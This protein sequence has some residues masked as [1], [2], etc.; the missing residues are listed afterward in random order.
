MFLS[1]GGRGCFGF[2]LFVL[3]LW[4][5]KNWQVSST[6]SPFL[7]RNSTCLK[8]PR[9][10]TLLLPNWI[11]AFFFWCHLDQNQPDLTYTAAGNEHA[12]PLMV[13]DAENILNSNKKKLSWGRACLLYLGKFFFEEEECKVLGMG[14]EGKGW[15]RSRGVFLPHVN[16]LPFVYQ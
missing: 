5:L 1:A 4:F 8:W 2:F 15:N 6:F 9:D 11:L 7:G 13:E 12:E 14:R 16:P 10:Y 3:R